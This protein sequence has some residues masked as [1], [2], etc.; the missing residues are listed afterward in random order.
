VAAEFNRQ[1]R[2][3][4]RDLSGLPPT[5]QAYRLDTDP[6]KLRRVPS[7]SKDEDRTSVSVGGFH[8]TA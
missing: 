5:F 8:G 7:M 3:K 2:V 1:E 4:L 6:K